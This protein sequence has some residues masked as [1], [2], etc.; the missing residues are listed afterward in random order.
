MKNFFVHVYR[1]KGDIQEDI[2][3][4]FQAEDIEDALCEVKTMGFY[5][6]HIKCVHEAGF[7]LPVAGTGKKSIAFKRYI[8]PVYLNKNG[9]QWDVHRDGYSNRVLQVNTGCWD[10]DYI[11]SGVFHAWGEE[12]YE[13]DN[14][15]NTQDSYAIVELPD[16]RIEHVRPDKIK[17]L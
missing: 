15:H 4:K 13:Q 5:P 10:D 17:F 7:K 6:M 9:E 8:N 12:T 14:G 11:H 1:Q 3:L 16:G 2:V